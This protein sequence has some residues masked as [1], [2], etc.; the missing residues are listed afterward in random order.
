MRIVLAMLMILVLT[1]TAARAYHRV[2]SGRY[3]EPYTADEGRCLND[4]C[5][6]K[7]PNGHYTLPKTRW[8]RR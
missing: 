2:S 3:G 7:H 1:A 8:P 5:F 4:R 6:D